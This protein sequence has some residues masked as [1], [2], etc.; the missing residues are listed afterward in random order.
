M[1]PGA[2]RRI[3]VLVGKPGLDGHDRGAR[4]VASALGDAGIEVIYS[5]LRAPP[6]V[7]GTGRM[8]AGRASTAAAAGFGTTLIKAAPGARTGTRD[9]I[10]SSL[11]RAVQRG[12]LEESVA[13]LALSQ[14]TVTTDRDALRGSELVVES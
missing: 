14:L 5:G 3:R 1:N 12:K 7:I 11:A 9:S 10:A 13:T 6:G 2:R 4:V 8:G